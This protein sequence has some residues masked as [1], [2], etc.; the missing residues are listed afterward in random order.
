[1]DEFELAIIPKQYIGKWK[2]E[3]GLR[4]RIIQYFSIDD[5]TIKKAFIP[6]SVFAGLDKAI[7]STAKEKKY[8][9]IRFV[10][11][12]NEDRNELAD[13]TFKGLFA[14]ELDK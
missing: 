12:E 3:E 9:E 11:N 10:Y 14:I 6:F 8:C 7:Y 2:T 4:L 5:M 1:M 13:I